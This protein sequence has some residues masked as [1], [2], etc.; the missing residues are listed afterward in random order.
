[1]N[2]NEYPINFGYLEKTTLKGGTPYTHRGIDY[3][4]VY[5]D[6]NIMGT[7]IGVSGES[8]LAEGPHTHVQAGRNEWANP[9]IDPTPYSG[10]PGKV[11]K[12]GNGSQWGDYVC[13]GVG[14]V[15]VF[16]CHLSQINVKVGDIIGEAM[17]VLD[18]GAVINRY[19]LLFNREP[20]EQ[21]IKI[22]QGLSYKKADD[23]IFASDEIHRR[24]D[25]ANNYDVLKKSEEF[26]FNTANIRGDRLNEIASLVGA[27]DS[28]DFENIIKNIKALKDKPTGSL[29]KE[30]VIKYV[31]ENLK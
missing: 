14:D 16:Y 5:Q 19:R 27:K 21:E 4:L 28:D 2:I 11:V 24:M 26:G 9:T 3:P 31:T 30:N 20:S 10:K 13:V 29:T 6:V 18:R 12:T 25:K 23:A 7:K 17:E 8:G 15:N 22:Y 1:M